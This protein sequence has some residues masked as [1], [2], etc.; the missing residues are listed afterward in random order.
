MT[1]GEGLTQDTTGVTGNIQA[2]DRFGRRFVLAAPGLG[3]T[4][5][6]LAVSAPYED[7]AAT[8]T[9]QVQIFPLD[10]LGAEVTYDQELVNS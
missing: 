4:K 7:G 6:R 3:D 2:G 10:D 9:G 1:P 8:D 5:T